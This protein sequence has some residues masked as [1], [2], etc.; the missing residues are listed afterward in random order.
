[1]NVSKGIAIASKKYSPGDV[2]VKCMPLLH[3]VKYEYR[4]RCCDYCLR[5]SNHLKKCSKCGKLNY[6]DQTCQRH[7]WPFHKLECPVISKYKL[8]NFEKQGYDYMQRMVLRLYL[9]CVSKPELL[10]RQFPLHNGLY[11]S[12]NNMESHSK[13]IEP[14][15]AFEGIVNY[16]KLYSINGYDRQLLLKLYG[17]LQINA[18]GIDSYDEERGICHCAS[19]LYIEGS[20]FDHNCQSNACASGEGLILE[21]RALRDINIDE[22]ITIDYIQNILPKEERH[23]ILMDRYYFKCQC[24]KCQSDFDEKF[25]F[26]KFNK[27]QK[28]SEIIDSS[29]S[30]VNCRT[31]HEFVRQYYPHFHPNYT[32]FLYES[33]KYKLSLLRTN[34]NLNANKIQHKKLVKE[35]KDNMKV[36]H[37]LN[38]TFY[39]MLVSVIKQ[40]F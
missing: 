15:K 2:I 29:I 27:L 33:L 17:I 24:F 30:A 40:D 14:T 1:M 35:V 36:T 5:F 9:M 28:E 13:E 26:Q 31:R 7:D 38:H 19:G 37:G 20:V 8:L 18:F 3:I 6:C 21:I 39:K 4:D 22:V 11:R 12:L 23:S 34:H 16:F 32:Y 25:D 10:N